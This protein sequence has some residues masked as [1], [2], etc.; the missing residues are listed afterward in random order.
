MNIEERRQRHA[1]LFRVISD[2]DIHAWGQNFLIALEQSDVLPGARLP[3]DP[4][5]IHLRRTFAGAAQPPP[6]RPTLTGGEQA[7]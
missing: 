3:S 5:R 6:D 7:A 4:E 2:N 1:A